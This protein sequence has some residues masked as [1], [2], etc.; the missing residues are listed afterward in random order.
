VF[1]GSNISISTSSGEDPDADVS[2]LRTPGEGNG[3][4]DGPTSH[5]VDDHDAKLGEYK[6]ND[7]AGIELPCRESRRKATPG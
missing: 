3:N 1:E 2:S 6:M 5:L 4:G 7:I